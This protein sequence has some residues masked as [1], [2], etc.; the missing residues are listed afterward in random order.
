MNQ[1]SLVSVGLLALA[2]AG[3]GGGARLTM[4]SR[5][6]DFREHAY[7]PG[8]DQPETKKAPPDLTTLHV[9]PKACEGLDV[10]PSFAKLGADDLRAFL[11]QRGIAYETTKARSDL[12]YVD[13]I[14]GS[15]KVRLRVAT[16]G[17]AR[18][19]GRD[20][21]E[22]LL[23]H[24]AGSWGVHRSN[25]AVLGPVSSVESAVDFSL[26]TK[27]ACW[28]VLTVAGRDDTFVVKGGYSEL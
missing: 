24:G 18:E 25:V 10:R 6:T 5:G 8:L 16:L 20:L 12:E 4:T 9:S 23:E 11:E 7:S 17:T 1:V 22:A 3:C 15:Q 2:L 21:H 14:D 13:L 27:L 28:G 19:A 26:R